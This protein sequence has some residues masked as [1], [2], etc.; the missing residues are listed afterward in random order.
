VPGLLLVWLCLADGVLTLIAL[1]LGL[2]VELNPLMRMLIAF[3][4]SVFVAVK[5]TL[6]AFLSWR[7]PQ[8]S[9]A[10]LFALIG[11]Y[12]IVVTYTAWGLLGGI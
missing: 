7:L 1:H 8:H 9:P 5:V 2:A 3:S 12:A 6:G 10:V 4:P 11:V